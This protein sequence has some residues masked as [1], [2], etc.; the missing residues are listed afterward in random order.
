MKA[1]GT[2]KRAF[3]Y[4]FPKTLPIMAGFLFLGASY[5]IYM[6]ASGFSFIY[7]L[8]MS[9]TIFGGSLEFVAVS[10]L[11]GAFDPL[12]TLLMTLMIQARHLFYGISML[13]K[14]KGT[15]FKKP[16]LIFGMCDESFSVNCSLDFPSGV[17]RGWAMFFVTLLNQSYWVSGATLGGILGSFLTFNTKGI[18]FVMTAMFVVIFLENWL[19]EKRHY[20]S[21]IG[22]MASIICL[23]I[24]GADSFLIPTMA[25]II[26]LLSLFKKPIEGGNS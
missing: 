6:K 24:F 1:E 10:M 9:I 15:G 3:L 19:K 25:A 7:P 18:E 8:I 2:I 17:D 4:A 14:Y 26:I 22:V 12:Q 13:Q 11:L 21:L 5:G 16:Y 20:S 23:L